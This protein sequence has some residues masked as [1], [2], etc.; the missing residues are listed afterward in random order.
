MKNLE[1]NLRAK[2]FSG[3][4][5]LLI[6]LLF[7]SPQQLVA[8]ACEKALVDCSVDAAIVG[9]FGG[10][11]VGLLYLSGCLMGYGWC[12]QYYDLT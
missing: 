3:L 2:I 6:C 10:P 4:L 12:I 9:L 8:G 1:G 7:L 11:K 5:I